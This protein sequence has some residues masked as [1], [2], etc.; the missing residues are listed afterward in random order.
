MHSDISNK[1]NFCLGTLT[2]LITIR[3]QNNHFMLF[4]TISLIFHM[5]I[6][7]AKCAWPTISLKHNFITLAYPLLEFNVHINRYFF[8]CSILR[9]YFVISSCSAPFCV[10]PKPSSELFSHNSC[11]LL[12]PGVR[13]GRAL[14]DQNYTCCFCLWGF[15]DLQNW[16]SLSPAFLL[17]L[18][19][20]LSQ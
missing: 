7:T 6:Y 13:I 16:S 10:S 3:T 2:L 18:S 8:N 4:L 1:N 14:S 17:F 9:C 11:Q 15:V 5:I 20:F 19:P 12:A